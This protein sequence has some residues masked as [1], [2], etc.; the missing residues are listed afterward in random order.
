MD[1][2]DAQILDD[3]DNKIEKLS[4]EISVYKNALTSYLETRII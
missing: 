2:G 3:L 4:D 1:G